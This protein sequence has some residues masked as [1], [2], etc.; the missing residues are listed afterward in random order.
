VG[1][2]CIQRHVQANH[3]THETPPAASGAAATNCQPVMQPV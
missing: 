1:C 3:E 2:W